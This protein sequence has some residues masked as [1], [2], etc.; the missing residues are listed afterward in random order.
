MLIIIHKLRLTDS[1]Y[2]GMY[3]FPSSSSCEM[4]ITLHPNYEWLSISKVALNYQG[5]CP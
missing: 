2:E 5:F 1:S 3:N 4:P